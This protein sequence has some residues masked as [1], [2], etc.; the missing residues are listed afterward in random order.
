MEEFV[1]ASWDIDA[2]IQDAWRFLND[3]EKK[4]VISRIEALFSEGLPLDIKYERVICAY[5]FSML[6]QLEVV[7]I[8]IPLK[9]LSE[10]KDKTLEKM[11]RRQLVDEVFHT[12]LFAKIAY[13][14]ASPYALPPANSK[15]IQEICDLVIN[16]ANFNT[17]IVLLNFIAEGWIE[18]LFSVLAK[19]GIA[20]RVF[21]VILEDERRH[22]KE[23]ELYGSLGTIENYIIQKKLGGIERKLVSNVFFGGKYGTALI[24]M[25][26]F[27]GC[28]ELVTLIDKKHRSQLKKL[29]L[30]P[31]KTW[32]VFLDSY[33][34]Y[35]SLLTSDASDDEEIPRT[36]TRRA[37]MSS[38][39]KPRDPSAYSIFNIDVSKLETFE[40]K[41]SPQALTGL[42]LQT[43]SKITKETPI[44]R[45][46]LRNNKIYSAKNNYVTLIIQLPGTLNNLGL[47]KFKDPHEM[48]LSV[49]SEHVKHDIAIMN[50]CRYRADELRKK[51]PEL[52][53]EFDDVFVSS[54]DDFYEFV[55]IFSPMISLSNISPWD[56]HT[57]LSALLPQETL[58]VVFGKTERKQVWNNQEK[59]F[60]IRD[61][62]NVGMTVDHR[63]FDGNM[64]T[65]KKAQIA[66][67]EMFEKMIEDDKKDRDMAVNYADKN[68]F[69]ETMEVILEK[70]LLL[71]FR[72][73]VM[74]AQ[75]WINDLDIVASINKLS[76]RVLEFA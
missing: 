44:L 10:I 76:N 8:Q 58:K 33:D 60:E 61:L 2:R 43:L 13:E 3:S 22:V 64:G 12:M 29:N 15:S 46:Y 6:T 38:W 36:I 50:Y 72:F 55:D 32:T 19:H 4:T 40:N 20:K 47:I 70:D 66:F 42:M 63:L 74:C 48:S 31:T 52:K 68:K 71:G 11:M 7:A 27:N 69:I 18:Q 5:V 73:I 28:K 39:T 26:G 9:F 54:S 56:Y 51:H 62:I 37:L 49:L 35:M 24:N 17:S 45:N 53:N 14:L 30:V 34:A 75:V 41:Y 25:I 23:A 67:D 16:E 57:G 21:E 65:P 59:K 1:K